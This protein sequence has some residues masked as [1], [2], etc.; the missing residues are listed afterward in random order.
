MSNKL[1][2]GL[3]F[4]ASISLFIVTIK[5]PEFAEGVGRAWDGIFSAAEVI[6]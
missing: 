1:L 4:M 3:L 6:K 5:N 2:I